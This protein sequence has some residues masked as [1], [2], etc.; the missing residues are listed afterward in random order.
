[1]KRLF[2]TVVLAAFTLMA[3]AQWAVG[4]QFGFNSSATTFKPDEGEDSRSPRSTN[5]TIAP[6]VAY[7]VGERTKIGLHPRFSQAR[8]TTF[9]ADYNNVTTNTGFGLDVFALFNYFSF[10]RVNLLA[11]PSVG[12]GISN[13]R[14]RPGAE[15]SDAVH[16]SR[17]S[18]F[19]IN[20]IPVI[21]F[22]VNERIM[23][24]ARFNFMSLGFS[25]TASRIPGDSDDRT[26]TNEF[27]FNVDNMNIVRFGG[28]TQSSV[29]APFTAPF[30]IGFLVKL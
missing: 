3:Q 13:G 7:K 4:G 28:G 24:I 20:I 30:T 27:G 5:F 22:H 14:F 15:G 19:G 8:T 10:G 21:D 26:V 6:M 23:L 17:A 29:T 1:M 16:N 18:S 2:I 25:R 12:F 9:L 11:K